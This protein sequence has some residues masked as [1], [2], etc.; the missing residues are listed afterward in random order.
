MKTPHLNQPGGRFHAS[1]HPNISGREREL[2]SM[3]DGLRRLI[4]ATVTNTLSRDETARWAREIHAIADAIEP[5]LPDTP[6]PRYSSEAARVPHDHFQY[7]CMLG[8]YN[9]LALPIEMEWEPP[10]AIGRAHF[11]TPYEGP[12]GCV[13]G[14]ILAAAFDQVFNI[15][16]MM[17]QTAGPTRELCMTYRKPTP[18][19]ADLVFEAH[20]DRVEGRRVHTVGHVRHGDTVTVESTGIFIMVSRERVE[21]MRDEARAEER[22]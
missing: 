7:D 16:N 2:R 8:L 1:S 5:G 4:A 19:H 14:A 12:P 21:E 6:P 9:P 11:T 20:V 13:H 22:E 3:A 10:N 18:L 15:A 17:G